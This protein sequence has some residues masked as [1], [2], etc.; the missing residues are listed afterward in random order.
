M[1]LRCAGL[2]RQISKALLLLFQ[3][4]FHIHIKISQVNWITPRASAIFTFRVEP[5]FDCERATTGAA[6]PGAG[7]GRGRWQCHMANI[8]GQRPLAWQRVGQVSATGA[9]KT[10]GQGERDLHIA[11]LC[12]RFVVSSLASQ[13]KSAA[14]YG[15]GSN[16]IGCRCDTSAG[17]LWALAC[18]AFTWRPVSLST[19]S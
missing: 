14:S 18:T 9:G 2:L 4:P 5:S 15:F 1:L 19:Q 7:R 16:Q 13:H 3:W 11:K 17:Y 12:R 8:N 10:G 6:N